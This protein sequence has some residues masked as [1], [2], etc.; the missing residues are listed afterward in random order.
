MQVSALLFRLDR[1][2]A[3]TCVVASDPRCSKMTSPPTAGSR[4]GKIRLVSCR[5]EACEQRLRNCEGAVPAD[6]LASQ[7]PD[8]G[9]SRPARAGRKS[10]H[11]RYASKAE[12]NSGHWRLRCASVAFW[13]RTK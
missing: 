13:A 3:P 10:G 9:H 11:I 6:T 5:R 7:M 8:K 1:K 12:L 4:D 2:W